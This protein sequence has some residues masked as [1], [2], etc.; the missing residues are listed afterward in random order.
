MAVAGDAEA[1]HGIILA[2]NQIAKKYGVKTGEAIWQAQEKCP[3]L[4]TL[5]ARYP[6]YLR[7]S[8]LARQIYDDYTDQ[9][10]PFG[11]DECWLDV[12]SSAKVHGSGEAIALEISQ[13]VK[14]EM[15]ITVSIG[16]SFNKIFAKLGSD[17]QKP[18]AI[19]VFSK[20]NFRDRVWP[21]PVEDLLYV[22]PA[23][24]R[25][26]N[27]MGITT[28]GGL[29]TTELYF[30]KH[31]FG[32]IGEVL[33]TFANGLDMTPVAQTCSVSPVKSVGNSC[34]APRDLT[35]DEDVKMLLFALTESVSMRLREQ[36][37]MARTVCVSVR[38]NELHS[39]ERQCTLK[40]PTNI[41]NEI[42]AIALTL[43]RENYSWSR[44]VR[45]LGVRVTDL[46]SDTQPVQ[47]DLYS[48]ET[49]R[50]KLEVLD[51]TVDWLRGRFGNDCIQRA[52]V[53]LDDRFATIDA[54][55]DHIIHP[56]GFF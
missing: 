36:G 38:D 30:L 33:Y 40:K 16:V 32:K 48:D 49:R 26:L 20:E 53:L 3:K 15:G 39:F 7:F 4:V 18:D 44:P 51:Q 11:I 17:Y 23:T 43:F 25:K 22:G 29:A 42:I 56:V 55:R 27:E 6:L 52:T 54:K 50:E 13:R 24:K 10:E 8:K 28:I 1:R 35:C 5:P 31:R 12:T 45:S 47:H 41:T 21:L 14:A 2:K 46:T 34:T 9:V 37:L 19:T